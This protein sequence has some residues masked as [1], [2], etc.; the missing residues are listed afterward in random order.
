LLQ[1]A[2]VPTYNPDTG[3]NEIKKVPFQL[4]KSLFRPYAAADSGLLLLAL[5]FYIQGSEPELPPKLASPNRPT[6][7]PTNP[8]RPS[9]S[10][11]PQPAPTG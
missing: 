10:R 8:H 11:S 5:V 7:S 9:P 4:G 2:M 3:T 1:E 6:Q